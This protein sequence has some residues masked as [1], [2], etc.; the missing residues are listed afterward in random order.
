MNAILQESKNQL[1]KIDLRFLKSIQSRVRN[2][3][4]QIKSIRR[5]FGVPHLKLKNNQDSKAKCK[6]VLPH[7][8][9]HNLIKFL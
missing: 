1:I 2:I 3:L 4:I 5:N 7:K 9:F 8:K 6:L